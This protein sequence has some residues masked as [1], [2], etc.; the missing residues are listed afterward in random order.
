MTPGR[1]FKYA[2]LLGALSILLYRRWESLHRA[3]DA[4]G[5]PAAQGAAQ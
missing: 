5:P 4:P 2:P 1:W 3:A